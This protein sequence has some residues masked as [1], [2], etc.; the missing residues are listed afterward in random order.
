MA[1][2]YS[3]YMW[4]QKETDPIP[5]KIWAIFIILHTIFYYFFF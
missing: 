1:R 5:G 4:M 3:I 2:K